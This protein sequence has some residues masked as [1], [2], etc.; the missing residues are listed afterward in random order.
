MRSFHERILT[1]VPDLKRD[2]L[3][4][5]L[6]ALNPGDEL[7]VA[8]IDCLGRIQVEV[9]NC[10]NEL[11]PSGVFVLTM[12]GP[13]HTHALRKMAPPVVGLLAGF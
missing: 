8:Q 9:I 10:L 7:L 5:C 1:T 4:A 6:G 11:L 3:Q 12:D 2:Q 13:I